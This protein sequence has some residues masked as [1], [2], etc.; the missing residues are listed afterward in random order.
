MNLKK[1]TVE[2]V[3]LILFPLS[4]L[5]IMVLPMDP[6][7]AALDP[8]WLRVINHAAQ[9]NWTWGKDI[10]FTYGPLGYFVASYSTSPYWLVCVLFQLSMAVALLLELLAFSRLL[11]KY[12]IPFLVSGVLFTSLA[13][14]SIP[15]QLCAYSALLILHRHPA[16]AVVGVLYPVFV[17]LLML[18]KFVFAIFGSF[19]IAV[20]FLYLLYSRKW[21]LGLSIVLI[22]LGTALI[23]WTLIGGQELAGYPLYALRSLQISAAYIEGM[24]VIPEPKAFIAGLMI[25]SFTAL[26]TILLAVVRYKDQLF[27]A[28]LISATIF[29]AWKQGYTRA[30]FGHMCT[31]QAT[32]VTLA[33][34]MIASLS[35]FKKKIWLPVTVAFSLVSAIIWIGMADDYPREN[36]S[37]VSWLLKQALH[38]KQYVESLSA[39]GEELLL[40]ET[41]K[42]VGDSRV[43]VWGLN[44]AQAVIN[45]FN[46]RPLP[47]FQAYQAV[48]A[49]LLEL[50]AAYYRSKDAP[51]FLLC[52]LATIDGRYGTQ[53]YAQLAPW[54]LKNYKPVSAEK[55]IILFEHVSSVLPTTEDVAAGHIS[56]G[57]ELE[58]PAGF[59]FCKL[60]LKETIL[61]KLYRLILHRRIVRLESL[62]GDSEAWQINRIVP[63]PASTGFLL[64][65]YIDNNATLEASYA[66]PDS[67]RVQK[68]R[69]SNDP[70][71]K[72]L[73]KEQVEYVLQ[74]MDLKLE[75]LPRV[76]AAGN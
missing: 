6:G 14:D 42:I 1:L 13:P 10:V 63:P 45:G 20:C 61:G 25:L 26:L 62:R 18:T 74:R 53:D 73:Y 64:S 69:I 58:I 51:R 8:G 49:D 50:N 31:F 39:Q 43:D 11:G 28:V 59:I 44:Q 33:F 5:L 35:E 9:E 57:Q 71:F 65:P 29:I 15:I 30:D 21:K 16:S 46:Y 41:A 2:K 12:Q 23:G 19:T 47:V 72:Y 27:A 76:P 48:Q 38:R 60:Q 4:L 66:N 55:S 68:I 3:Y 75:A 22:Y 54:I 34:A 70:L 52:D 17:G 37:K 56:L 7:I 24:G 36:I 67:T 32:A 40:P